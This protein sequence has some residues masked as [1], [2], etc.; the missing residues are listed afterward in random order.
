MTYPIIQ[1]QGVGVPGPAGTLIPASVQTGAYTATVGAL[2]PVDTTSGN[3]T[4]TL[5]PAPADGSAIGVALVTQGGAN[6]VTV[7]ASGTDHFNSATGPTTL[8]L[9]QADQAVTVVYSG[10]VWYQQSSAGNSV[11]LPVSIADG[12][13]GQTTQPGALDAIAGAVTAG[14]VLAGD[15]THV[16]LRALTSADLPAGTTSAPGALQIEGTATAIQAAGTQAAGSTGLAADGGHVHPE[17]MPWYPADSGLALY[18]IDP[19]DAVGAATMVAGTLYLLRIN[20]RDDLT[21]RNVWFYVTSAGSGAST[22]SYA[23]IYSPTGSVLAATADIGASLTAGGA[24]NVALTS[25]LTLTG[26]SFCW[27]ALLSNLATTQPTLARSSVPSAG[28]PNINLTPSTYRI[29]TGAT[30]VSSLAPITPGANS[31]AGATF[32]L[33]GLS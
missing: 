29:A 26:G 14:Q 27:V 20:I 7:A 3:V 18:N 8:T 21:V 28:V 19:A 30:G 4:I 24:M 25:P 11:P 13:T 15:G 12:G 23:G 33:V 10:G 9:S 16:T 32:F 22:G 5:P 17:N 1:V 6:T 2:V 31:L